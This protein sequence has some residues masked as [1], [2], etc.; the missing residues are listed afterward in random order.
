MQGI[1]PSWLFMCGMIPDAAEVMV[2]LF[3]DLITNERD[4][5]LT[6]L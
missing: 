5:N 1:G 6:T 3:R 4:N 2:Y